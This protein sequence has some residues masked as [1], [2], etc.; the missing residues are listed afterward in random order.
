MKTSL[1]VIASEYRQA[2]D[3]LAE[4]DLDE[5]TVADTLESISGDITEKATNV[6]A[7]IRNLESTAEAVKNAAKGMTDRAKAIEA[8]ADRIKHYL[9]ANMQ[10]AGI[11][12]IDSPLFAI[13]VKD[14]PV[15][16]VIDDERQIPAE[17]M[18]DPVPPPPPPAK[19]DK[20]LIAQAIKDGFEVPGARLERKQRVEIK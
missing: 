14:N 1:Y 3:T 16:V 19:P 6:A 17:Y 10:H 4:L 11:K 9:L 18:T 7:F 15:S 8:R 5:Q 13:T 2:A 12:K 20:K